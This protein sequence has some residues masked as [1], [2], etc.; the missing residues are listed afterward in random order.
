MTFRFPSGVTAQGG[1]PRVRHRYRAVL[2]LLALGLFVASAQA[3]IPYVSGE[4]L[5]EWC[6]QSPDRAHIYVAG[7]LDTLLLAAHEGRGPSV[8][9]PAGVSA[10]EVSDVVCKRLMDSPAN[11]HHNTASLVWTAQSHA[12][13]CNNLR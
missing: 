2:C 7:V 4:K 8:C 5:H 12:W 6:H 9:L 1:R 13:P 10:G 3:Q 11:R